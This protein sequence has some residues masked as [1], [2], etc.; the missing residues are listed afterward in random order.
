MGSTW[1]DTMSRSS[2]IGYFVNI[3]YSLLCVLS[4]KS[5]SFVWSKM[6]LSEN[7]T[8]VCILSNGQTTTFTGFADGANWYTLKLASK[9]WV[10]YSPIGDMVSLGGVCLGPSDN[11]I[12]EYHVVIGLLMKSLANDVREIR[13]YLDLELVVQQLNWVYMYGTLYSF[14]HSEG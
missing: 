2:S 10:L 6:C 4:L 12:V 3:V 8:Y 13:V 5:V 14:I 1:K 9:S 11:N 7:P